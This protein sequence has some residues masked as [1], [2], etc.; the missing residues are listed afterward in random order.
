[1]SDD[2]GYA[3]DW[4]SDFEKGSGWTLLPEGVYDFSVSGLEKKYYDGGAKITS[5]PM[6]ELTLLVM[7]DTGVESIKESLLLHSKLS[8]KVAQFWECLGFQAEEE[9]VVK[10]H[11]NEIEGLSGKLKLGVREWTGKDG[12][13]KQF[14]EVSEWLAPENAAAP[15]QPTTA[16]AANPYAV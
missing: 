6:A 15:T 14:N 8:W 3:L 11:W 5:C 9:G 2:Q 7:T 12:T 10:P 16:P 4:D 13:K 1:M